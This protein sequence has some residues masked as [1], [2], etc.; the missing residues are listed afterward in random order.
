[1]R[2]VKKALLVFFN[3]KSN[4]GGAERMVQY[5]DDYLN[6]RGI[7]TEIIDE[8]FLLNTFFGR[9]YAQLFNYRH[10]QKRKPIYMARFSSAYLWTRNRWKTIVISNGESTPFF[11]ADIVVN[12][13]CYH[14]MQ[15]DYGRTEEKLSRI[16]KLQRLGCKFARQITTV[17]ESVKEDL[18][19]YYGIP[20]E[21]ITIIYNRVDATHFEVLPKQP[22][23]TKTILYAGRLEPGKGIAHLEKLATMVAISNEW[24][25]L[26]ACNNAS[27][28]HLFSHYSNTQVIIGLG[29]Q[30]INESAYSKAD[31]V[32]FPSHSES[33]GMITI[34]ALCAGVPVIGTPVGILRILAANNF[35]GAHV[36]NTIDESFLNTCKA[37]VDKFHEQVNRTALH[38]RVDEVFGIASYRKQWDALLDTRILTNH[39]E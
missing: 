24:K 17:T 19:R 20:S 6:N 1:M 30:N 26:I 21:K 16:A 33:F 35:P 4:A 36:F 28:V 10:F 8:T 13:G 15:R 11:P 34:E 3:G 12:Q 32:F 27:N 23:D 39:T 29:L 5:L 2:K 31:L 14:V 25:L 37:I 38:H 18:Q 7:S 22:S 9:L